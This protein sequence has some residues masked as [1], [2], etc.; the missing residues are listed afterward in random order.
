MAEDLPKQPDKKP[1]VDPKTLAFIE[2]SLRTTPQLEVELPETTDP[3]QS[4]PQDTPE[5]P[6]P[7][8]SL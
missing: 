4:Q 3:N 6:E 5:N 7:D 2:R 8:Q 1:V